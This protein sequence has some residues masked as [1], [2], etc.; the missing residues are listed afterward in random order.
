MGSAAFS[1]VNGFGPHQ[2]QLFRDLESIDCI[3]PL[4]ERHAVVINGVTNGGQTWLTFTYDPG[5]LKS[6]DICSLVELLQKEL[7][8]ANRELT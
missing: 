2:E 7:E 1:H 4:D 6:E 8:C 5:L 3:G